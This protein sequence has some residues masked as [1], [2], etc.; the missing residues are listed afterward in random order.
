MIL[1]FYV[2]AEDSAGNAINYR[3][4]Q[5]NILPTMDWL[6]VYRYDGDAERIANYFVL[7]DSIL[8]PDTIYWGRFPQIGADYVDSLY[9]KIIFATQ[10]LTASQESALVDFLNY[11][12]IQN[13]SQRKRLILFGDDIGWWDNAYHREDLFLRPYMRVRYIQDDWSSSTDYDTIRWFWEDDTFIIHSYYPDMLFP[14]SPDS[15]L[16]SS[17][18]DTPWVYINPA[19]GFLGV[20]NGDSLYNTYGGF[21]IDELSYLAHFMPFRPNQVLSEVAFD[22][23]MDRIISGELYNPTPPT[24]DSGKLVRPDSTVVPADSFTEVIIGFATASQDCENNP[25]NCG[26][27]I[28]AQV[29]WG[30][31]NSYPWE[32]GWH[33]FGA[34]TFYHRVDTVNTTVFVRDSFAGRMV[35]PSQPGHYDY[36]YR[37]A[38]VPPNGIP[39]P[40]IYADLD[41]VSPDGGTKLL[42]YDYDPQEAGDMKVMYSYDITPVRIDTIIGKHWVGDTDSVF[43]VCKNLGYYS[44]K[45][46]VFAYLDGNLQDTVFNLNTPASD[47][48]IVK[49]KVVYGKE[50]G[51]EI[52]IVTK[53]VEDEDKSND[54]LKFVK[55]AKPYGL[56]L[57]ENFDTWMPD[58][59]YVYPDVSNGWEQGTGN[60]YGD[61][62]AV[63]KSVSCGLV[64][65]ESLLKNSIEEMFNFGQWRYCFTP[66]TSV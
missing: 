59:W 45:Y 19:R 30:P 55:D 53:W 61:P 63:K 1:Y 11:G 38:T 15:F 33:W 44:A 37:Y 3:F 41:G 52:K 25:R 60:A 27:R 39:G 48:N 14:F 21:Y 26:V 47:S 24:I 50:S 62:G 64:I 34:D 18:D 4:F 31:D 13:Y 12:E 65:V 8:Y 7:R 57:M 16:D 29:G 10:Y 9:Q 42:A 35:A 5:Y 49:L 32:G 23:I 46:D 58:G 36:C 66:S 56:Y 6:I 28:I 43:V 51:N 2:Q 40:W 22:T 20:V 17:R 54:T